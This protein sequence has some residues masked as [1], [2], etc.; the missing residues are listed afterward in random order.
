[1]TL[2]TTAN[3]KKYDGDNSTVGFSFPYLFYADGDLVVTVDGV[4][5]TLNGGGATGFT[6][7]GAGV[8]AGG[9]VT[10]NTAPANLAKIIIQRIVSYTQDTD[11]A[12]F[13]GNPADVTE[14]QFDLLTMQTQQIAE[15]SDRTILAPIGTALTSNSIAGTIDDTVRVL[16]VTT[17]GPATSTLASV[18]ATIDTVFTSLTAGDLLQ[19]DGSNWVNLAELPTAQIADNAITLDK[20][21]G[22]TDGNL[23]TFDANGDPAFVAT[24]SVGQVLT[25]A[26][27]GAPPTM[28]TPA[29][30]GFDNSGYRTNYY[31]WPWAASPTG[32]TAVEAGRCYAM[33]FIVGGN[34]TFTR[35]GINVTTLSAGNARLGIYN[36][37]DG[38]PTTLVLD[39]GTVS[40]GSTGEKEATISQAL[41]QGVYALVAIFDATPT[42]TGLAADTGM[43]GGIIGGESYSQIDHGIYETRSYGALPSSFTVSGRV[44]GSESFLIW[45]RKV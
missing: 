23:I 43:V 44:A 22:G 28:Q 12:D 32:T 36:F 45:L 8:G 6:V 18:S 21:A 9:T 31:Y 2:S 29:G 25:S 33:P 13:D 10:F 38:V 26:G 40:T 15:A 5:Y 7:S 11:F 30:G 4:S 42:L 3:I 34:E 35:I 41:S 16:T 1:M 39:A 19:Y 17:A 14:K 27:A 20:I 24:G 37:V